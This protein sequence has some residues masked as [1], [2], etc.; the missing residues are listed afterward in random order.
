MPSSAVVVADG[1]RTPVDAVPQTKTSAALVVDGR[2]KL[3]VIVS[4]SPA[5]LQLVD[6]ESNHVDSSVGLPGMSTGEAVVVD[7]QGRVYA[8]GNTEHLYRYTP[9]QISA[10]D[11]GPV[12][13]RASNVFALGVGT[14]GV[15]WG[16][17]YPHAELWRV[18]PESSR[19]TNLGQVRAGAQYARRV[20]ADGRFV[21]VAVGPSR[22]EII[23]I[24]IDDPAD[25]LQI[26]LPDPIATG[27]IGRIRLLGRFL[28]VEIP[29]GVA[30][31]GQ[32]QPYQRRLYDL[33]T[34][35]W[36]VPANDPTQLPSPVS[37][38]GDF[39]YLDDGELTA[40]DAQ[41]GDVRPPVRTADIG[42][43][44]THVL[45]ATLGGATGERLLVY[46]PRREELTSV[47]VLTGAAA[48]YPI[49]L[50]AVPMTI[51][52]VSRGDPGRIFV[53]G[54]GGGSLSIVNLRTGAKSQFP[55]RPI[56]GAGRVIGEIEGTVAHGRYQ[57]LG[58]YTGSKVFQYDRTQ[59]WVDGTN[60]RVIA[61]LGGAYRQDRPRAWATAGDRVYFGTIPKYGV[62]GGGLGI[63]DSD[64]TVRYIPDVVPEQ[65]VVSL[66]ARGDVVV[67]GTS[68]W[69]GL[70]TQPSTGGATVFA[71]D[72]ARGVKIW[73]N[74]PVR[75]AQAF[76][77]VAFD[78]SG[79]VWA[80]QG[81]VL[82]ELDH[83]TGAVKRRVDVT[84]EPQQDEL[85]Y[86]SS[87]L[88]MHRGMLYL[89]TGTSIYS[90]DPS[91]GQ[92]KTLVEGEVSLPQLVVD[93]NQ[94]IYPAGAEL[95][96]ISLTADR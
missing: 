3:A 53:G 43:R 87:A 82:F 30:R 86:N 20:A 33:S 56:K 19:I 28:S 71:Y 26:P 81:G 69:G 17:S 22:P 14:D 18:A 77:A 46:N 62:L 2:L 92:S 58:S 25:R 38:S 9:G 24:S 5:R 16:G 51:K 95:R 49:T 65:S 64:T 84:T 85:T 79:S 63:I 76:G 78:P 73:E 91:T 60:P 93:D 29:A 50:S 74:S 36:A 11:L 23:R 75:G 83:L 12:T 80:A 39:Y 72:A 48:R 61:D 68:R 47:D 41:S 37:G 32:L 52:S 96:S 67:G 89:Q 13:P 35:T 40:V 44:D 8:G 54:Y 15:V 94:L 42:G 31:S 4:G 70:G 6:V 7:H 57:Y 59:P 55:S 45:H 21:Y 66:A 10:V 88:V 1:W 34:R 90:V 27:I